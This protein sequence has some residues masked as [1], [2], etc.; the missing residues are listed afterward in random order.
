MTAADWKVV[1]GEA[2]LSGATV[3]ASNP[4]GARVLSVR[5]FTAVDMTLS[6]PATLRTGQGGYAI[7]V[8]A[9]VQGAAVTGYAFQY[10]VGYGNAYVL[11]H[12][13]QGAECGLP[14]A[15]AKMPVTLAIY[16]PH[17]VVVVVEG[18]ALRATVDGTKVL[19]VPSL[20]AMINRGTCKFP[21]AT[22]TG[23]GFRTFGSNASAVFGDTTV[24]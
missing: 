24:S 8:R 1:F 14:L 2:T 16:A 20:T 10:D 12:W 15:V 13:H 23:V 19:D 4:V 11:R 6:T 21:A 7:W 9:S 22:G 5:P 3:D 17:A 18:D